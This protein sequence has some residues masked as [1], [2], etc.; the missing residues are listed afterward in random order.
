M[1]VNWEHTISRWSPQKKRAT[2]G[3]NPVQLNQIVAIC[4]EQHHTNL[5]FTTLFIMPWQ[6]H[7]IHVM[8]VTYERKHLRGRIVEVWEA[9]VGVGKNEFQDHLSTR[10]WAKKYMFILFSLLMLD[11]RQSRPFISILCCAESL[12]SL[13]H[14]FSE[15]VYQTFSHQKRSLA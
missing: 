4:T 8:K 10:R 1:R 15:S 5:L 14:N 6:S 11:Q 13:N 12:I 7:V 3:G 2:R 9:N